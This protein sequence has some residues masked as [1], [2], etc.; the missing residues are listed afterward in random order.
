M[1]IADGTLDTDFDDTYALKALSLILDEFS[2]LKILLDIKIAE[3]I[4]S[5][6]SALLKSNLNKS[7]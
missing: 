2:K 6:L 1:R 3:L 7:T 4:N 5:N